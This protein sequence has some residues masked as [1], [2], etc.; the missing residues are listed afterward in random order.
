MSVNPERHDPP[1]RD[2]ARPPCRIALVVEYDGTGFSGWQRQS[3][4]PLPTVQASLEQALTRIA[5]HPVRVLCAGRTDAGVHATGQ[6]VHFDARQDRG[7]KAWRRGGNSL[8][9]DGVCIRW[10]GRVDDGFHARFSALSRRYRYIILES[11]VPPALLAHNVT[12]VRGRLDEQ[13]MQRAADA[14]PGERDFSAFRAAGCQSESP[15][16]NVHHVQVIRRSSLLV[17]DIQ[18]N[19][20]LQHMVRNIAGALIAVGRHERPPSWVAELLCSGDRRRGA[21]TA[22]PT[23]LYLVA[24]GYPPGVAIPVLPPGPVF[25]GPEAE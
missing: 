2:P 12:H 18:A 17:I 7:A 23:G 5:D 22:S 13:A 11:D 6:V 3:S 21:A 14:L 20:F 15:F 1:D 24:V 9:P 4:P 25:L 19:A 16:R 8:L 10:A